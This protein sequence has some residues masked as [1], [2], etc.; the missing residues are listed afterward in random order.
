M[1]TTA[2]KVCRSCGIDVSAQKRTKD[3]LGNYYCQ[4]CWSRKPRARAASTGGSIAEQQVSEHASGPQSKVPS[5]QIPLDAADPNPDPEVW[6]VYER[7]RQRRRAIRLM[8]TL[9]LWLLCL[10]GS[11][12]A[13][14]G[15]AA[16]VLLF[17]SLFMILCVVVGYRR[18]TTSAAHDDEI[19]APV[20]LP[21]RMPTHVYR[22][23]ALGVLVSVAAIWFMVASDWNVILKLIGFFMG[24]LLGIGLM[25]GPFTDDH[26]ARCPRCKKLWALEK[27]TEVLERGQEFQGSEMQKERVEVREG[28]TWAGQII[29][30]FDRS[31]NVPVTM[32]SDQVR[33]TQRCKA[34]GYHHVEVGTWTHK[35]GL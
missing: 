15:V 17:S 19:A 12:F 13:E 11:M 4:P 32:R 18:A 7:G 29:A 1:A 20:I 8:W 22:S 24:L 3:Q 35:V 27:T 23:V 2:V 16:F 33:T 9:P 6:A 10:V 31:V 25:A 21:Q 26:G 28:G 14:N 30:N 34:C 5:P